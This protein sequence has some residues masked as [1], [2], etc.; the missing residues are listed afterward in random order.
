M[1]ADVTPKT[2]APRPP[3]AL[4]QIRGF[5]RTYGIRRIAS[6]FAEEW[7]G[8]LVRSLPGLT[9]FGLRFL[10]YRVLFARLDGFCFLYPGARIHHAYGIRAGRNLHVNSNVYIDGRGGLTIGANVLLGPNVVI[11]TSQHHWTDPAVPIVLQGHIEEP[12]VI[13]DDVW[14]GAQ[15]VVNP[16]VTIAAGTIVGAGAV[17]T[18]DTEPYTIVAGVPARQIGTRP[19]PP[20]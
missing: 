20:Q 19:R 2:L 7:I 8:W 4:G 10:L 13:G 11:V 6:I 9:G 12:V 18:T 1:G 5:V 15:A 17:V 16:G 3:S 14:V